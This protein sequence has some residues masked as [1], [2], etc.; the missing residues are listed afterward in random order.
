MQIDKLKQ[1]LDFYVDSIFQQGYDLGW[2]AVVQLLDHYSNIQWNNG[3]T[4]TAEIIRK[5]LK[6]IGDIS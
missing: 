4:S 2:E 5:A 1:Q 3:N 6:D